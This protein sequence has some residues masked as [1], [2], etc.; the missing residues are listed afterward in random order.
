MTV[1]QAE[2]ARLRTVVASVEKH[3]AD[4]VAL[5]TALKDRVVACE[6]EVQAARTNDTQS[7]TVVNDMQG[8]L[9][10]AHAGLRDM[11]KLL[12]E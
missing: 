11:A 2:V 1:W 4:L 6:Q 10:A 3:K 8:R 7:T 12:G 9:E 5:N